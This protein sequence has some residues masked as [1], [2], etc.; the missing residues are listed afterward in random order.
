MRKPVVAI[1]AGGDSGEH[2]ISL[3]SARMISRN[4]NGELFRVFTILIRGK[5]W[6]HAPDEGQETPVDKNDFSIMV[7][8]KKITFDCAF[9][10]IHGTPGEDGKLQGY[11]ELLGIPYTTAGLLPT[12]LTANK[13]FCNQLIAHWGLPVARSIKLQRKEQYFAESILGHLDLPL[14]VKPNKGGSSLG[15]TKVVNPEQL[16]PS[17]ILGFEHDDELLLEEFLE[18]QEFTCG[19]FRQ[20]GII[21]ALP[22]TQIISKTPASFFDF[23]AKYTVGAADEITP[24]PI[25][26]E[27]TRQIQET[28]RYIYEKMELKGLA[29]IDYIF[30]K[31]KLYFLEVNITPGMSETSIVPQQA[32]VEGIPITELFTMLIREAMQ[33]DLP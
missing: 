30:S 2:V 10:T 13:Y 24:A 5:K 7:D 29:R 25:S 4:I 15:T 3:K 14:I 22:V 9:I 20:Q 19:V 21:K 32:A 1:I 26:G 31:E 18:G 27:L 12:A 8:G 17:V 28:T 33:E 16:M 6:V 23:Q 11:F